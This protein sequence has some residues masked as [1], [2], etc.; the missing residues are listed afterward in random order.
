MAFQPYNVA[1]LSL[2]GG[3]GVSGIGE[4]LDKARQMRLQERMAQERAKDMAARRGL[5]AKQLAMREHLEE[6]NQPLREQQLE[7]LKAKVEAA[8]RQANDP[9]Q[10]MAPGAIGQAMWLDRLKQTAGEDSQVYQD[11]LKNHQLEADY[12][13]TM[14]K[15]YETL[16]NSLTF[17]GLPTAE[18]QRVMGYAV[19]MGYDP[20]DATKKLVGGD[21]LENLAD[22]KGVS[23]SDVVPVYPLQ[24][25]EIKNL[26]KR[27]AFVN[28]LSFLEDVTSE[29]MSKYG[30]RFF[31]YSPKQVMDAL[32]DKEPTEQGKFLAARA[33]QPELAALRLKAAN[34]NVGIE[35]IREMQQ[36][37]LATS[38]IFE[39]LVSPNARREM[40][41][42][43]TQWIDQASD[44][45]NKHIESSSRLGKQQKNKEENV[46]TKLVYNPKTGRFE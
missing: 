8:K 43:V 11:A 5:A 21:T 3:S 31:G 30:R 7:L 1:G 36:S 22:A 6:L 34:G 44:V 29:A 16:G 32:S 37:A 38:K 27:R 35:A 20:V 39:P 15:R 18:R 23:L 41:K 4:A 28:E 10:H 12:K 25:E 19:G 9:Y 45:Y 17:R 40:S 24:G 42:L 26:R 13:R 33:L 2:I 14:M 46:K